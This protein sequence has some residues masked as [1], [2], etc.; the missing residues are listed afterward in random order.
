MAAK[1]LEESRNKAKDKFCNLKATDAISNQTEEI[2]PASIYGKVD[3]L[4]VNKETMEFGTF[5][6]ENGETTIEL[7]QTKDNTEL[8][9][10]AAIKTFENDGKVF[11]MSL[12]EMPDKTTLN[13][14]FRY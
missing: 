11:T 8:R 5:N 4:F 9:N 6:E 1:M 13:A 7:A 12:A 2:V 14:I 10:L 3:T